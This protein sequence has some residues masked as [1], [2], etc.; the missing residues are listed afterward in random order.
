MTGK[1]RDDHTDGNQRDCQ[2]QK[3]REIPASPLPTRLP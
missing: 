3:R 2:Q 1:C